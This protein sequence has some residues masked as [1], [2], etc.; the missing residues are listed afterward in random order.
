M[1]SNSIEL[2]FI[3]EETIQQAIPLFQEL[4]S[5]N[6]EDRLRHLFPQM[7]DSNYRCIGF[8]DGDKLIGVCGVW[9]L[10]KHY[11]GKHLE[12]DNVIIAKEYRRLKLGDKLME[13]VENLALEEGNEAIELNCHVA[14]SKG[15][16][17]W[18]KHGFSII[19]FHFQKRLK[20]Q[21]I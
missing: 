8:F 12:V 10:V 7:F 4:Y 11:V 3:D 9:S 17:F 19:G 15:V 20:P 6:S 21:K 5:N 1:S 18:V 14:N 2:R 16:A 13:F